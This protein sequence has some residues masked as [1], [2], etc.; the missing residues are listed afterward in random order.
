[1]NAKILN[2]LGNS[3]IGEASAGSGGWLGALNMLF[4]FILI[5]GIFYFLVILP[6]KK[7]QKKHAQMLNQL[8]KGDSVL[9]NCG[10]KGRITEIKNNDIKLEVSPKVVIT[11][12]K[13]VITGKINAEV[14][15]KEN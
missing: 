4:P 3:I 5:F 8:Q 14:E 10:I 15:S 13:G 6:Q 1:M 11:I 7:Q 9:M 12:Q 2:L